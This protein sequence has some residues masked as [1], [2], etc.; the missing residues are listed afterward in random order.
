MLLVGGETL[1]AASALAVSAVTFL[2]ATCSRVLS[3]LPGGMS[4]WA[5]W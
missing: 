2:H 1:I 5:L 3:A 4:E